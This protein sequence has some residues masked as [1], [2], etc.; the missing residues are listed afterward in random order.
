MNT[1]DCEHDY[2]FMA[3]VWKVGQQMT[4]SSARDMIYSDR[5]Y[6]RKCLTRRDDNERVIGNN[7][8]KPQQGTVPA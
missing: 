7:Y 2:A 8:S 1:T 6:C 5:F 3:V 4:G